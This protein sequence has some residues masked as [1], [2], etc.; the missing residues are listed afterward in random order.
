MPDPHTI[1]NRLNS[2]RDY[3]KDYD[4]EEEQEQET[5]EDSED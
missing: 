3:N 1:F 2:K 5:A 4:W